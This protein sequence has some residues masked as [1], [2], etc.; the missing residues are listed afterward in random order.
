M[1]RRFADVHGLADDD[2]IVARGAVDD[3]LGRLYCLEAAV[4]DVRRDLA[5]DDS[6][7]EVRAALDWLLENA[8]PLVGARLE[9]RALDA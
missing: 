4:E 9:P 5:A 1:A 6:P 3:L 2:L 7:D 8:E